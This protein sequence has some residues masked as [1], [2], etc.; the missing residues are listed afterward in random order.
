M[1]SMLRRTTL[2]EIKGSFG[3]FFAI[4][5]IIG[6]GVGFFSGV[7][8]TK[9][10][11]VH[12][13]DT[14]WKQTN[15][16][17][18]RL[19]STLGFE[20]QDVEHFAEEPEVRAAAGSYS[21]DIICSGISENETILKVHSIT[22]GVNGVTLSAGRM[23][24]APNECVLDAK[25]AGEDC[26]GSVIQLTESNEEDTLDLLKEQEFTVVGLV[27]SAY[28]INFE[29]GTTSLGDG[30]IDG[31]MCLMPEAIDSEY[32]TEVFIKFDQDYE[33]YSQ[34]YKD[35]MEERQDIWEEICEERVDLRY[36]TIINDAEEELAD[37]EAELEDGRKEGETELKEAYDELIS[38]E[39]ELED[40]R[41]QLDQGWETL[42]SQEATVADQEASLNEQEQELL[43]QE[44]QLQAVIGQLP[45][46]Q[47]SMFQGL[48]ATM[49]QATEEER[50]GLIAQWSVVPEMQPMIQLILTSMQIEEGKALI[51]GGRTALEDGKNQLQSARQELVQRETEWTDGKKELNEGWQEYEDAKKEFEEEIADGE[52]EIADAR[53]ELEDL[54]EPDYYV[55]DRNTNTGY[56]CFES[57]SE[58]INAVAK[59]FPI[60]F[61][62]VAALVCMTTMNRMVEEQRTQIG[63]L[64]ALGYNEASIMGKFTFYSGS[65]AF[66]GW[67]LGYSGGIILFPTVIWAAYANT[68][69]QH[70]EIRYVF[71]WKLALIAL[72]VSLL[73]SI[74]TTWLS[75]R[76]ELGENAA[77]LMRAK[78]P[79][80]GKRVL[81]E[82]VPFIWKRLKFLQ[83]VSIRN[84]FRYK[85]R[86]FM[87][88]IGI[89]G[90][91][92]LLLTG[93]GL[94]D[95]IADFANQQYEEILIADGTV[96]C[97]DPITGNLNPSLE[98]KLEETAED[99]TFASETSWDLVT[100]QAVKS[101]NLL[102]FEQPDEI[103]AYMNLFSEEGNSISYPEQG[104]ALI[105]R[106]L[107][108][109]YGISVGDT[110]TIRNEDMEDIKT[111]VSGIFENHVYNYVI[112]SPSTYWEQLGTEPDYKTIYV[113][114]KEN[115]DPHQATADLM[116][117]DTVS[118]TTVFQDTKERLTNMM[119]SLNYVVLLVI[120]CAAALA[121][122]VLYNLTNINITERIR[123]I[124]TIKVLGFFRKETSSYVFRENMVLT[125]FGIIL[126]LGLGVLLHRFVMQQIQIDMVSFDIYIRPI[127]F[128]YSIILTFAFHFGV[129]QVMSVKLD[130]INMAESLKS[131]D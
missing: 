95:S 16:Y 109:L 122:I 50:Q 55:L 104:Q 52:A 75:C 79:K 41:K 1:K 54:K 72:V 56:V 85:K 87:M 84:I 121:F 123:E 2:R 61:I 19:I 82:R 124:A 39:E 23:P 45:V 44:A 13:I 107:A 14:Y 38:A 64:K 91:T 106:A 63:I 86:F 34:E 27:D 92:A 30:K 71:S 57:D 24:E 125:G 6:L 118:T 112:L 9:Q 20:E 111:T 33:I 128:L 73:C 32:Y 12:T 65:A 26:L 43:E 120:I 96:G 76:Y 58:I 40:G 35:Y 88:V 101:I 69:Y 10:V 53:K 31:F 97:K 21:F 59:V 74:G 37:A 131:V 100:S 89:S 62:L 81:L 60:F 70:K 78:A 94:K 4:L 114:F 15:F 77:E 126:G 28:Y 83:K 36:E 66:V 49:Q 51:A 42:R 80:A 25:M 119:S 90:C 3:R 5:A 7:K 29:R 110:I 115:M 47:Q 8:I 11:M 46:E 113:N 93:F 103:S 67:L 117:E 17:D 130:R 68:M 129:D 22:E 98:K 105:N 99:Y 108:D 127:S 48:L 102:I 116:K 18:L